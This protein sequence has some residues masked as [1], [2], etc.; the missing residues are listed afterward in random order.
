MP[1]L[2]SQL[3]LLQQAS[4]RQSLDQQ[5]FQE[6]RAA[7]A[8]STSSAGSDADSMHAAPPGS[9]APP[10]P[11]GASQSSTGEAQARPGGRSDMSQALL[12][13]TAALEDNLAAAQRGATTDLGGAGDTDST[14]AAPRTSQAFPGS[15]PTKINTASGATYSG[16]CRKRYTRL[17]HDYL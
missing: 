11:G 1:A 8:A 14:N 2:Y 4:R 10:G 3:T 13:N 17:L 6:A 15:A 9:L 7:G 5:Q 12:F 16:L